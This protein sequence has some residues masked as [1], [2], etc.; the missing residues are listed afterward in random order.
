MRYCMEQHANLVADMKATL[1][2]QDF[3]T[4]MDFQPLPAYFAEISE[5]K[6]GNMLGLE[7]DS[8][9]KALFTL[10]VNMLSPNSQDEDP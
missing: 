4:I 6:G 10:G 7:P 3:S 9:N 8:R 5:Q 1:G 2:Q